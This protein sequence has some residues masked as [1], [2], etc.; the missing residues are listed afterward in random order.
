NAQTATNVNIDDVD[1]VN[2]DLFTELDAGN[3]VVLKFFTDW[4]GIC[5]NT[6]DEVVAIYNGF[7]TNGDPVVFWALDRDANETNADAISYRNS[8]M[9]PF[10]V[11]GEA[12][13]VAAQFSV[14]YQ[15]EYRI[16]RPDRSYVSASNY[17]AMQ[18]A[19]NE[20][21]SSIAT[22]IEDVVAGYSFE[23][24]GNSITWKAPSS[25]V[26]K[27][28]ITDASGRAVFSRTISG[29]EKATFANLN[30]GV[31]IYTLTQNDKVLTTGK[32]GLIQ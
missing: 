29:S 3:V 2:R 18:T 11:I 7:Q 31:Y 22:G 15:P 1:G 23:V 6:A 5:H 32:I 19:V 8:E 27:L 9:I 16:I 30:T 21:L 28:N 14:Q 24:A 26:A 12:S 13:S 25:E 20:A 4:C 10:P 17:T